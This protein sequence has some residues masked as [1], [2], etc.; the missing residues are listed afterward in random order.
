MAGPISRTTAIFERP[1]SLPGFAEVLPAGEYDLEAEISAPPDHRDPDRWKASVLV[2]LHARKSHPGLVRSLTVP[3]S[4]LEDALGR[5]KLTGAS[6]VDFFVEEMLADPMVQLVMRAD[7]VS[8]AE[9]RT[10]YA[11]SGS[12]AAVPDR[13]GS[14]GQPLP[15]AQNGAA[16]QAAENEGMPPRHR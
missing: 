9:I 14:H 11:R 3:L 2:R 13:F 16:V 5:D 4:A 7:R 1:F 8:E 10:L 6:L 15:A 12:P